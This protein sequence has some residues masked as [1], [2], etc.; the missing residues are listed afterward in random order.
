M[1]K[2]IKKEKKE[3]KRKRKKRKKEKKEIRVG[4]VPNRYIDFQNLDFRNPSLKLF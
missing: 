2:K 4:S 3:K 1:N